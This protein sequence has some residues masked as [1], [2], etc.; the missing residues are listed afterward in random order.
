MKHSDRL[1][2]YNE[3]NNDKLREFSEGSESLYQLLKY[4]YDHKIYT[5]ACCKGHENEISKPYISFYVTDKEQMSSL[6]DDVMNN[7]ESESFACEITNFDRLRLGIYCLGLENRDYF[8][9]LITNSL[10]NIKSNSNY[11]KLFELNDFLKNYG[12]KLFTI[13]IQNE[14]I[15]LSNPIYKKIII[16]NGKEIYTNDKP[17]SGDMVY[18]VD[19]RKFYLPDDIGDGGIKEGQIVRDK[20]IFKNDI[21]LPCSIIISNEFVDEFYNKVNQYMNSHKKE[22]IL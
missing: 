20:D 16:E 4:C 19:N 21:E 18:Q 15:E 3:I 9:D 12:N 5:H 11:N 10:K 6:I 13:D 1:Y 22:D 2:S 8:F 14:F 17:S 7:Y